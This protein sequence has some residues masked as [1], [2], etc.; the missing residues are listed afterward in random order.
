MS[1]FSLWMLLVCLH[2]LTD[3]FVSSNVGGSVW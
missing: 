3:K 1:M 2:M